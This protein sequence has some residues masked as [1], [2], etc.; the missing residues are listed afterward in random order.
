MSMD[1]SLDGTADDRPQLDTTPDIRS[2]ATAEDVA[3]AAAV[4]ALLAGF[5]ISQAVYALAKLD[6]PIILA[7][8]PRT[9]SE[10]AERVGSARGAATAGAHLDLVRAV[11]PSRA[12]PGVE[13]A[14]M[15]AT[16]KTRVLRTR[17]AVRMFMSAS[18]RIH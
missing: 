7:D 9:V 3:P 17:F 11:P 13:L 15:A 18:P 16:K 4:M 5:Q 10:L 2:S 6:V 1:R 14:P 12:R 8:G